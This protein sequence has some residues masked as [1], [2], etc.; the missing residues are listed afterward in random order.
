[1]LQNTCTRKK[2]EHLNRLRSDDTP[3]SLMI[4]NTFKLYWIPSKKKT[5]KV[6]NLKYLPKFQY[7]EFWNK[8]LHAAHLLKLLGKMCKWSGS[9]KYCWRYRA[10][11][12]QSTDRQT[13]GQTDRRMDGQTDVKTVYPPPFH[14]GWGGGIIIKRD[15]NLMR[16]E[17]ARIYQEA[18]FQAI[19]N[20]VPQRM[21]RKNQLSQ[22][23]WHS[24]FGNQ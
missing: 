7:Y 16:T 9:D 2:L 12:I 4:T 3:C 15:Q 11:T 14:L 23:K 10:D 18:K 20:C 17:M 19:P 13:D 8:K 21:P 24:N 6:T 1:M 5:V 22:Y